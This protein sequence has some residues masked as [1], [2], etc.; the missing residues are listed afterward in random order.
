M[1]ISVQQKN[2]SKHK[3]QI[4]SFGAAQE[5]GKSCFLIEQDDRKILLDAGLKLQPRRT[6]LNSIAP[7]GV[8]SIADELTAV[9][10]SHAH[11]DHSGYIPGLYQQGYE[12]FVY[13]TKPTIPIAK[14][15]WKDHLKL[16]GD[17]HY[18]KS[19]FWQ[20]SKKIRGFSYQSTIKIADGVNIKFFD[21]GHILGSACVLIEFD[22]QL[23]YYSGDINDQGGPFHIKAQTPPEP[24]DILLVET[25]NANRSI[26]KR[27]FVAKQLINEIKKSYNNGKKIFIPSFALGRSQE[28]QIY[29][30][31]YLKEFLF[32]CPV[33]VDGLIN[34][35]NLIYKEYFLR[36]WVSHE[37]INFSNELNIDKPFD[38]NGI[39]QITREFIKGSTQLYRKKLI[40]SRKPSIVLTTSGMMEGGP[41]HSYLQY[42]LNPGNLLAIVGYQVEG[43]IGADILAGEREFELESQWHGD[44]KLKINNNVQHFDFS[45]HAS[46]EGLLQFI[47]DCEPRQVFGIHGTPQSI[48]TI[49]FRLQ[50]LGLRLSLV[51]F[52]NNSRFL[53][54]R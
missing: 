44:Y 43:T 23:I 33:Y 32:K 7:I 14:L 18:D 28:M 2:H 47:L 25:T 3:L 8:D 36:P 27:Q 31:K 17:L 39:K 26:P 54:I 15:L 29:L 12:G 10:L 9:V 11:L 41:I 53:Q 24:V 51:D 1:V 6:K 42:Q 49:D 5:V 20:A 46:S 45:G 37:I 38:F 21:A 19:A 48:H 30:I 4:T 52:K 40:Q 50:K 16:E 13:S 22:G 34:K 35:M